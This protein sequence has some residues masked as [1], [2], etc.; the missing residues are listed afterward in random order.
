[1][2]E[3]LQSG[4]LSVMVDGLN[5]IADLG[6]MR[7][8]ASD[9]NRLM[10][11]SSATAWSSYIVS[12]RLFDYTTDTGAGFRPAQ[13]SRSLP[14]LPCFCWIWASVA[15]EHLEQQS[16][17]LQALTA[18][19][20]FLHL[21]HALDTR[22]KA[23]AVYQALDPK[24]VELITNPLLL[25]MLTQ[26]CVAKPNWVPSGK[27]VMFHNFVDLLLSR[28]FREPLNRSH[29]DQL[30]VLLPG[31]H[32]FGHEEDKYKQLVRRCLAE[33]AGRMQAT[34]AAVEVVVRAFFSVLQSATAPLCLLK[35]L[36][37]CGL[38]KLESNFIHFYHHTFLVR[39]PT[40]S[41]TSGC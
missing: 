5:E 21:Q 24:T 13:C 9:L 22:A 20:V 10:A 28:D 30:D 29:F 4:A 39:K 40:T 1:M 16:W 31:A 38:L 14:L 36:L 8:L 34:G 26:L 37:K 35:L 6:K 33:L 15:L 17:E 11:P 32:R 25:S 23:L 41:Q 3:L 18:D 12:S 27:G 19:V 7:G 2:Q